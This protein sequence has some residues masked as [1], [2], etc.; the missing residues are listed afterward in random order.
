VPQPARARR[1]GLLQGVRVL[2]VDDD[3][4]T[5]ELFAVALAGCGA[6]VATA[7]SARAALAL[8]AGR[9]LDVVVTD[10]AMPG[11]DGYWLV[12]EI[13]QLADARTRGLP[14][15]AVTA[16]GREHA[17]DRLLAAGFLES[18]E[19]PVDPVVLCETVARA[20]GA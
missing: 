1:P 15:V 6:D 20:R 14:V 10:I 7:T 9:A 18:L 2:V 3:V 4:D 16:F 8:M 19:K 11:L 17:R 12:R 5:V 13:R